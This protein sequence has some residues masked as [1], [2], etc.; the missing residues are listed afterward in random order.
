MGLFSFIKDKVEDVVETVDN[1]VDWV[2][3]K[4]AVV[5]DG[6]GRGVLQ[7]AGAV[8]GVVG[9]AE[10]LVVDV[11]GLDGEI[12][13]QGGDGPLWGIGE[14]AEKFESVLDKGY[15]LIGAEAPERT[16]WL[17]KTL[18]FGSEIAGSFALGGALGAAAK[19]GL[20]TT[21]VTNATANATGVVSNVMTKVSGMGAQALGG[22]IQLGANLLRTVSD[23]LQ[24]VGKTLLGNPVTLL[25]GGFA[26]AKT[27]S[28]DMR[29]NDTDMNANML[30]SEAAMDLEGY[31]NAYDNS[32]MTGIMGS[33]ARAEVMQDRLGIDNNSPYDMTGTLEEQK[34]SF[35]NYVN[36]GNPG[37]GEMSG[38]FN[39][40]A[41]GLGLG[42][43]LK[44]LTGGTQ[45][46]AMAETKPQYQSDFNLVG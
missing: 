2:E 34:A 42:D 23:P 16:G 18:G 29:E 32:G 19:A 33:P 8:V 22:N 21:F 46:P 6:V 11:A 25:G 14:S 43:M 17:D 36:G 5:A 27:I 9:S 24:T 26:T 28:D 31:L 39:D 38:M 3:H 7:S 12:G 44:D 1:A 4:A 37:S 30:D 41:Q 15:D 35:A 13:Y 20:A 10:N 45:A 40:I